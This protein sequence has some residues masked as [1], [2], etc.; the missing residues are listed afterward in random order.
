MESPSKIKILI[1]AAGKGKRMESELP[2]VLAKVG[3]KT[4]IGHLIESIKKVSDE[5]PIA[6]VGYKMEIV[7][8]ELGDSCLYV[9]QK[10][11]LGTGHA[12]SCAEKDCGDTEHIVVLSGD[13]PFISDSTIRNLIERHLRSDAIITLATTRVPDFEDW[14]NGFRA[15]GRILRKDGNVIGIREYKD[16]NETEKE[17]K[18]VNAGSYVF[19]AKWLWKNLKKIKNENAQR[20]YYLTDLIKIATD[21]KVRIK[22]IEIDAREA[23]GAN[24]KEELAILEKFVA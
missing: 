7:K 22:S 24:S 13:Q 8:K 18:E 11:Q 5:K 19:D 1:L 23:L 14:K 17:I 6:I 2:K 21:E 9:E 10:E 15:F 4:M 16:A 20:E 3:G 12:I